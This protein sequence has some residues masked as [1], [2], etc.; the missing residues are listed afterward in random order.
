VGGMSFEKYRFE[1]SDSEVQSAR[2]GFRE[3]FAKVL[4]PR[5]PR[6]IGEVCFGTFGNFAPKVVGIPGSLWCA[7]RRTQICAPTLSGGYIRGGSKKSITAWSRKILT[8]LCSSSLEL[9]WSPSW[10]NRHLEA[11]HP[12]SGAL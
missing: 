7:R 3:K 5:A 8:E 6:S 2:R 1:G 12:L 10:F 4:S 11:S 9:E